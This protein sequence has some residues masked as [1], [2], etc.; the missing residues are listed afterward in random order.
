MTM[1]THPEATITTTEPTAHDRPLWAKL[2]R[3]TLYLLTG[4]PIALL[5]FVVLMTGLSLGLSLFITLLG[6]PVL[7][8]VLG[9]ARGF[10]MVER[11]RV[12]QVAAEMPPAPY[13]PVPEDT[14]LLRRWFGQLRD[15]QSW[16]DVLHG[17]VVLPVA[18][19]TFSIT[20]VW[21]T[22]ALSGLTF[23]FWSR[24]LPENADRTDLAA[25]LDIPIS[26]GLAQALLGLA[27]AL[28]LIPVLRG[29][30]I[31]QSSLASALLGNTHVVALQERVT[32]LTASRAAGAQAEVDALRRLERDLH[33]GPQQR[34]VRL[35]MDLAAAERR[36]AADD[37][38]QASQILAEARAQSSEALAELRALTRGIAPPI[39]TDRGLP[40]ALAALAGRS[41]AATWVDV[42][43]PGERP[44]P[45]AETA[46]Y[47]VV[48][49]ALTNVA[50]HSGA[51]NAWVAV[52]R[53]DDE[54]VVEVTD[55]GSGGASAAKGHGLSGLADRVAAHDGT[56]AINSP[57]GGPTVVRAVI[58]CGR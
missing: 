10:A 51:S 14:K 21:W 6:L 1:T 4:L 45:A 41:G 19:V 2:G 53:V 11:W 26:E 38:A 49:E 18:V 20:L 35:G 28:T 43:L 3:D 30:A 56:L 17:V 48:S 12:G 16:L 40:D 42:D 39:L 31:A 5:S 8:V 13:R 57:A 15:T 34:L 58:P 47:F 55:D 7:V 24:Y 37:P 46:A 52:R 25:L 50:K 27:F 36:L 23:W 54:L 33:D 32:T 9:I 44:S 22:G 29:C